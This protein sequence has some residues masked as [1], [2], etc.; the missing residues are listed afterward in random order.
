MMRLIAPYHYMGEEKY[1]FRWGM[2]LTTT[3]YTFPTPN[4]LSP[5]PSGAKLGSARVCLTAFSVDFHGGTF[6][7]NL[8]NFLSLGFGQGPTV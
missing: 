6:D 7:A 1:W 4:S 3:L 5:V 2:L 8:G